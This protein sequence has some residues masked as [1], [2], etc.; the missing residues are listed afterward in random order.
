M[1][2]GIFGITGKLGKSIAEE[3]AK[4]PRFQ[5]KAALAHPHSTHLGKKLSSLL[6]TLKED[7]PIEK[8]PSSSLDLL[9][10][11]S[12]KEDFISRLQ[13]AQS[14][15][16]PLVIG[17][18]GL[19]QKDF[20][21]MKQASVKIPIFYTPNFSIAMAVLQKITEQVARYFPHADVSISETHHTHKKDHPSGSALALAQSVQKGQQKNSLP[22]IHSLRIGEVVGKHSVSFQIGEETL[23]LSHEVHHR[24]TFAFGALAASAYLFSQKPG[25]YTMDN[26]LSLFASKTC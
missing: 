25:L 13:L 21:A 9:I 23:T 6:P 22:S 20:D 1:K 5:L 17:T 16:L 15:S 26:L 19:T 14:H 4:D 7:L 2:I 11:V 12:L 3:I 8:E 18:T 24:K 10:D